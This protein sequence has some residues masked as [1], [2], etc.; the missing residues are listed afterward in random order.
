MRD[1][2]QCLG[3]CSVFGKCWRIRSFGCEKYLALHFVD[4]GLAGRR[5]A[6]AVA[7]LEVTLCTNQE[8]SC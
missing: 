3:N 8:R 7:E 2:E 1:E 4:E 6:N 5:W